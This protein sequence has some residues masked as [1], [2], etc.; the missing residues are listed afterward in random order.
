[1]Y[2]KMGYDTY[3][4]KKYLEKQSVFFP[5]KQR[6]PEKIQHIGI[7]AFSVPYLVIFL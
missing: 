2:L 6:F 5:I 1:M 4:N 3:Y 7:E